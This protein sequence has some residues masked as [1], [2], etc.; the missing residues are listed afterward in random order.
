MAERMPR[1]L[2][3]Y[4]VMDSSQRSERQGW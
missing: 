4:K 2:S 3:P 1:W